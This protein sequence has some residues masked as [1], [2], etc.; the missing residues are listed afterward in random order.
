[1]AGRPL[2]RWALDQAFA[3]PGLTRC[4]VVAPADCVDEARALVTPQESERFVVV[5]GGAER[6]ESVQAGLAHVGDATAV[7]IHDAAR[8]LTPGRVFDDVLAALDGGAPAVVPGLVVTDTIKQVDA[9]GHVV[10]TPERATLRAIQTPQ[11]F[12]RDVIDAAHARASATAA[13]A[14]DDA[15]LVEGLGLPVLVVPGDPLA[16]KITVGTDLETAQRLIDSGVVGPAPISTSE[17]IAT[18]EQPT[19]PEPIDHADAN[20]PRVAPVPAEA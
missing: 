4:V 10:A 9:D 1:M 15:A 13:S 2:L 6:T 7:L 5:A 19:T 18:R 8:C 11:G 12:A 3:V 14:T 20:A 16:F 17:P